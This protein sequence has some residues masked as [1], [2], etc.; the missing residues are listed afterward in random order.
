MGIKNNIPKSGRDIYFA[1]AGD[2]TLSGLSVENP[3]RLA[4]QGV[5]LINTL[6]PA[7]SEADPTSLNAEQLSTSLQGLALPPWTTTNAPL[8]TIST[9]DTPSLESG[10]NQAI[11]WADV[12]NYAPNGVTVE[13]DGK[14]DVTCL[15][16]VLG[17]GAQT[18]RGPAESGAINGSILKVSGACEDIVVAVGRFEVTG[19]GWIAI[20]HTATSDTADFEYSTSSVDLK[21]DDTTFLKFNPINASDQA[22]ILAGTIIKESSAT[23]TV[24]YDI[25]KGSVSARGSI[26]EADTAIDAASGAKLNINYLHVIG[27]IIVDGT[28]ECI[29]QE[30]TG[31]VTNNGTI[32]GIINGVRFGN[33]LQ[34]YGNMF[35]VNNATPTTINTVDVFEDVVNFTAGE[36]EQ[37][38]FASSTLATGSISTAYLVTYSACI[39]NSTNVTFET[40]IEIDGTVR[41]ESHACATIATGGND[42]SLSGSFILTIG[43]NKDIK[44]VIANK[45]N[46]ANV[47]VVDA[48]VSVTGIR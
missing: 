47:I 29:I 9:T 38:T 11:T 12:F 32:N 8:A 22:V 4:V 46:T 42:V 15:F 20:D 44:L 13:I 2:V 36:V 17:G 35:Q 26:L 43:A 23:G 19:E 14:E 3:L 31:T 48:S 40:A 5:A 39:Q 7:S 30:H 18:V 27:D 25:D 45:T 1:P 41:D 24:G 28:L 34:P 37:T 33:W 6:T 16:H 10:G 21:G